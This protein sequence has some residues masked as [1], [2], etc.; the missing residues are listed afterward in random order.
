MKNPMRVFAII[1][2]LIFIGIALYW[3]G[4]NQGRSQLEAE[5]KAFTAQLEQMN[6]KLVSAEY[7]SRLNQARF[8]LCRTVLDLD[9]RNFGL[10][11]NHLKEAYAALGNINAAMVGIDPV[12]FESLK[13]DI[14]A[15][16]INVAVNL[17]EQRGK[18]FTFSEQLEA[19]LPRTAPFP[20]AKSTSAPVQT[21]TPAAQPAGQTAAPAPA[22]PASPAPGQGAAP[23]AP[24]P[25]ATAPAPASP[26]K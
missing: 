10:A 1:V 13:K 22:Q 12:R 4:L 17:E 18:V 23:Q 7:N 6:S 9:Q 19:L 24:A 25:P 2:I 8:F 16:D 5:Q 14:A 3:V 21:P 15:T 26:S 20:A 11:N